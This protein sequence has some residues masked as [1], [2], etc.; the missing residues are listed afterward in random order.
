VLIR[1]SGINCLAYVIILRFARAY[2]RFVTRYVETRDIETRLRVRNFAKLASKHSGRPNGLLTRLHRLMAPETLRE[3]V[4]VSLTQLLA[5]MA[6]ATLRTL[7]LQRKGSPENTP[8]RQTPRRNSGKV[9]KCDRSSC[10][11]QC[12]HPC[13]TREG[14]VVLRSSSFRLHHRSHSAISIYTIRDC[15]V[16]SLIPSQIS[17]YLP[18]HALQTSIKGNENLIK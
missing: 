18:R 12:T 7:R 17:I 10:V 3:M 6:T 2:E 15:S 13:E 11:R 16:R 5:I 8:R 14:I 9:E 1:S 4:T